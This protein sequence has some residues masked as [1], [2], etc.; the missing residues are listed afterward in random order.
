VRQTARRDTPDL[1]RSY[2]ARHESFGWWSIA[3]FSALGLLLEVL[4]GLKV[5][6]YLSAAND[7]RRLMWTLAHAHGVLIGLVQVVF[8]IWLRNSERQPLERLS[9]ISTALVL[10]G[11]LLPAGFLLGGI[12]FYSGDPGIGVGLVPAGAV[13]LIPALAAVARAANGSS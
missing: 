13:L 12:S 1:T 5:Q 10:A 11:V 8:G 9:L 6:A 3:I 2:A 4:H 7:T